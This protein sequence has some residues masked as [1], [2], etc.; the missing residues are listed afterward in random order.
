[1]PAKGTFKGEDGE[2]FHRWSQLHPS[3]PR[4]HDYPTPTKRTATPPPRPAMTR[5]R[6]DEASTSLMNLNS[7]TSAAPPDTGIAPAARKAVSRA[8]ALAMGA[9]ADVGALAA[10][11]AEAMPGAA[12]SR[13]PRP[14]RPQYTK[15]SAC[16]L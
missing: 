9:V 10:A 16:S 3:M 6:E 8:S 2:Y 7:A 5:H 12:A 14:R 11:G 4:P 1:M 13:T 15:R